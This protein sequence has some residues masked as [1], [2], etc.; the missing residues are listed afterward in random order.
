LPVLCRPS[1]P[2]ISSS[3]TCTPTPVRKPVSTVRERKS[4]RKPSRITR[5]RNMKAPAIRAI[6]LHSASHSLDPRT[7]MPARPAATTA[8]VAESALTERW[9][10]EPKMAN[11]HIGMR[12]V[13]RPVI[14]GVPM[15]LV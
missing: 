5:A 15:I 1:K 13:Y 2:E 8:A 7:A 11:R 14:T 12:M 4:A 6:R 10:D 3:D 9:R